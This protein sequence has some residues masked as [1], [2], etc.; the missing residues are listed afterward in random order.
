ML[1]VYVDDFKLAGPTENMEKAWASIKRAVN[2]GDPELK[3]KAHPFA[4][5]FDSQAAAAA[6][7]QH[8]TTDFWQHDPIN[9]TWTRYHLQPRKKFFEP[10]DEGGSLPNLCIQNGLQCSTKMLNLKVSRF[11]TCTCQMKAQQLWKMT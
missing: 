7:T 2:I 6:R 10:G 1:V 11:S 4:H 9:K 5:F 3:R 8:R